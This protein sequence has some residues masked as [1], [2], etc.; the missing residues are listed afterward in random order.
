MN[1]LKQYSLCSPVEM[2]YFSTLGDTIAKRHFSLLF[3]GTGKRPDSPVSSCLSF[4]SDQSMPLSIHFNENTASQERYCY[5]FLLLI[6][7]WLIV[8]L[9]EIKFYTEF[10]IASSS[11]S[12]CLATELWSVIIWIIRLL[13]IMCKKILKPSEYVSSLLLISLP[14]SAIKMLNRVTLRENISS[15][16]ESHIT[17]QKWR[18]LL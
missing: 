4:K 11:S 16:E 12:S 8:S 10:K 17:A 14:P 3:S 9:M 1:L 2:V 18:V 7:I 13:K 5:C 6:L 15:R